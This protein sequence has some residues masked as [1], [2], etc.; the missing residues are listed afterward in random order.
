MASKK[1]KKRQRLRA[2]ER[3]EAEAADTQVEGLWVNESGRSYVGQHGIE[4]YAQVTT[5][6]LVWPR[7]GGRQ[8]VHPDDIRKLP[9][10]AL[11][12]DASRH[13]SVSPFDARPVYTP[14]TQRCPTCREAFTF[15]AEE[16]RHWY[17][18]LQIPI[19]AVARTCRACRRADRQK[20]RANDAMGVALAELAAAPGAPEAGLAVARATLSLREAGGGGDLA[21]AIGLARKAARSE[22]LVEA[23][24]ELLDGLLALRGG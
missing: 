12:A 19:Q 6:R 13:V 10:G 24:A 11:A 17:E 7:G 20:K 15:T 22:A 4:G 5:L 1:E 9:A 21:R 18:V 14:R 3:A 2:A 23:A 16:Q 8:Q